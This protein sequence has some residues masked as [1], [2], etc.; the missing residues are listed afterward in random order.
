[1]QELKHVPFQVPKGTCHLR[2]MGF[3]PLYP[4]YES[5]CAPRGDSLDE[6]S[7]SSRQKPPP[8]K[9]SESSCKGL[10]DM[11]VARA[12]MGQGW[13]FAARSWKDNGAKGFAAS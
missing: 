3:A 2:R 11:D 1:M 9:P 13:P 6:E 4:S 10:S 8:R 7:W 12:A 5:Q